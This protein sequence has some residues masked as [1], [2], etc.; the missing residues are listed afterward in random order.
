MIGERLKAVRKNLKLS[1]AELGEK[2]KI[3]ASAISQMEHN[4]IKPSLETLATM[5]R[6]YGVNLHW[7]ITGDGSMYEVE[8]DMEGSTERRL[9]KIRTF[10][11]DE[12]LSLVRT[13]EETADLNP[14]EL[15]VRGEI[16]A[17]TPMESVDHALDMISVNRTM[18]GG[19][20]DDFIALRVNGRSM[21]P[22]I[23][24]NDVVVIRKSQDWKKLNGSIC[25]V[26]IDG[27]ITLKRLSMDDKN[28]LIVLLSVNEEYQPILI[29]PAEHQDISLMGSLH[30]LLR[31]M[32]SA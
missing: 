6:F 2:L 4:H 13:K 28:R 10:I 22:E 29:N 3:N 5:A 7:L 19:V 26:R 1:Q 25:A 16:P 21:E 20:A 23:I 8:G 17:G 24:H 18:L 14:F 15:H 27:E 30:M 9:N 11:N 31:K 32:R 12:L